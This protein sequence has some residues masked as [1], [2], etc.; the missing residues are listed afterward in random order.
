MS[1][2]HH[3]SL[4][5]SGGTPRLRLSS[6]PCDFRTPAR[7]AIYLAI[8]LYLAGPVPHTAHAQVPRPTPTQPRPAA[9]GVPLLHEVIVAGWQPEYTT[10]VPLPSDPDLAIDV[11]PDGDALWLSTEATVSRYQNGAWSPQEEPPGISASKIFALA[12]SSAGLWAFGL[13]GAAW[14]RQPGS[15]RWAAVPSGVQADLYAAV[16]R[17]AND[18]WAVGFDWDG[19]MGTVVHFDGHELVPVNLPWLAQRQLYS[20]ALDASGELW[21]GGCDYADGPLLLRDGKAGRWTPAPTPPV[22]GCVYQLSFSPDGRGLAAAGHRLWQWDGNRWTAFGQEP[23]PGSEWVRVAATNPGRETKG[24]VGTADSTASTD[25]TGSTGGTRSTGQATASTGGTRSTGQ[26]AEEAAG[27]ALPGTPTWRG[28]TNG[29]SPWTYDGQ[30]WQPAHV[31]DLGLGRLAA[32]IGSGAATPETPAEDSMYVDLTS[33]GRHAWTLQRIVRLSQGDEYGGALFTLDAGTARL[34]HPLILRP[35]GAGLGSRADIAVAGQDVWVGADNGPFPFLRRRDGQWQPAAPQLLAQAGR[36]RVTGLDFAADTDG[37]AW[38]IGPA[39]DGNG[40]GLR[41]AAWH[42]DGTDWQSA[43]LPMQP[44]PKPTPGAP[45]SATPSA[46]TPTAPAPGTGPQR[47]AV[48]TPQPGT[49][50]HLRAVP[51]GQGWA[52]IAGAPQP[53]WFLDPA[54][55]PRAAQEGVPALPAPAPSDPPRWEL[56]APYDLLASAGGGAA[57]W[58]AAQEGPYQVTQ[59]AVTG[60][61]F[62][63]APTP[64]PSIGVPRGHVLDLQM[65]DETH[66]WAIGADTNPARPVT[67]PTGVLLRLALG[68]RMW[69]EVRLRPDVLSRGVQRSTLLPGRLQDITDVRW[70]LMSAV[71]AEEVWLYGTLS[72]VLANKRLVDVPILMRYHRGQVKYPVLF[73]VDCALTAFATVAVPGGTDVWTYGGRCGFSYSGNPPPPFN[74]PVGRLQVRGEYVDRLYMPRVLSR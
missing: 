63:K 74:G 21:A 28:F 8:A 36:I 67:L 47:P 68:G 59:D 10:A 60:E 54:G 53:L 27:W 20:I 62:T 35:P 17:S 42:W 46:P 37:W 52:W 26:P 43:L 56:R 1:S 7:G 70:A 16:T 4:A 18:V 5:A 13:N 48:A 57:G 44:V 45:P 66:G 31:D 41:M 69:E 50:Q 23:P 12:P 24:E 14:R 22:P 38:G 29:G 39:A 6:R 9:A 15:G 55:R 25:G 11:V 51:G 71:S 61:R 19:E 72:A 34:A 49:I 58:W 2:A 32:G 30:V 40:A 73:E 33:D 65:L 3:A 64:P